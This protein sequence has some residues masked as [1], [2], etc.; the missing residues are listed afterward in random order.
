MRAG[1]A[2]IVRKYFAVSLPFLRRTSFVHHRCCCRLYNLRGSVELLNFALRRRHN[3]VSG[4]SAVRAGLV[5]YMCRWR[6]LRG[7][8][9]QYFPTLP[10]RAVH[11]TPTRILD[12]SGPPHGDYAESDERSDEDRGA[13]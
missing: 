10:R 3:I 11:S 6:R 12:P 9:N 8:D 5:F 1:Q 13:A 2:T 7:R 4:G